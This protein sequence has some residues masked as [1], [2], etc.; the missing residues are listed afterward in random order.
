MFCVIF[1]VSTLSVTLVLENIKDGT[2]HAFCPSL[3]VRTK[4]KIF[5]C[6]L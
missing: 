5:L 2:A 3:N 1:L 4:T 6:G